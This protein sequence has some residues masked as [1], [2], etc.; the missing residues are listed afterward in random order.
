M[1]SDKIYARRRLHLI[2]ETDHSHLMQGESSVEQ[3]RQNFN[4][5]E[6][7]RNRNGTG[8]FFTSTVP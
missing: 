3:K 2:I 8:F 4:L 5:P 6:L 7:Q 1:S